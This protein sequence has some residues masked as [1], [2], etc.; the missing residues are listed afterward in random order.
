[1]TRTL[2]DTFSF[3]DDA[4]NLRSTTRLL[5]RNIIDLLKTTYKCC[6]FLQDYSGRRFI[7]MSICLRKGRIL[8]SRIDR[9]VRLGASDE[10]DGF[11]RSLKEQKDEITSNI[12]LHTALVS[13]RASGQTR[14]MCKL[15]YISIY[16]ILFSFSPPATT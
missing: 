7:G 4:D 5:E 6:K 10:M 16:T 15:K 1:M 8:S 3:V 2:E 14:D 12:V 9:M 13:E 11:I